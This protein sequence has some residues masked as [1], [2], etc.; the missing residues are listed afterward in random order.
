MNKK[1]AKLAKKSGFVFWM[2]ESQGPGKGKIDWAC[3]YEREFEIY[4]KLVIQET[5]KWVN[6]NVGL[7]TPAANADLKK[8]FGVK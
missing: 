6:D 1:I 3:D 7:V 4:T 5:V 2:N 8:H